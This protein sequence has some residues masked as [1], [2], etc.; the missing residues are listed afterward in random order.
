MSRRWHT[1]APRQS[2]RSPSRLLPA[3]PPS[4]KRSAFAWKM[5]FVPCRF[6][7]NHLQLSAGPRLVW[8]RSRVAS[9]AWP[10]RTHARYTRGLSLHSSFNGP[11]CWFS[12]RSSTL[13]SAIAEPRQQPRRV[14]SS[15]IRAAGPAFSSSQAQRA[16]P[17]PQTPLAFWPS[18][19]GAF[20]SSS[21]TCL[22]L[23]IQVRNGM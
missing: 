3:T 20:L 15:C 17:A 16:R 2:N 7:C 12:R 8:R 9:C 13:Y 11:R 4:D 19:V 14:L 18:A 21:R 23:R 5:R 10:L 22:V 1:S 6:P